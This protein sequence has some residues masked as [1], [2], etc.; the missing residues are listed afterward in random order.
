MFLY[1]N[2]VTLS[3]TQSPLPMSMFW[4]RMCRLVLVMIELR[5]GAIQTELYQ[6]SVFYSLCSA[7]PASSVGVI[8]SM[9]DTQTHYTH[10][11]LHLANQAKES[12]MMVKNSRDVLFT[13]LMR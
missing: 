9:Y 6:S 1:C 7:E 13:H 10:H 12:S 2:C 4:V 11:T 3:Y 8:Y 5:M